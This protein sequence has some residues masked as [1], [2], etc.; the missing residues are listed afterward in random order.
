MPRLSGPRAITLLWLLFA[1]SA[2]ADKLR[3]TSKPA[4]ATVELDGV[5]VG[6]TPLER[7]WIQTDA[8]INPG[9]SGGPLL[10]SRGPSDRDQHE[11]VG[12]TGIQRSQFCAQPERSAE[13]AGAVLSAGFAPSIVVDRNAECGGRDAGCGTE[14]IRHRE[15]RFRSD[16]R[17][18]IS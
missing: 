9:N 16:W 6:T 13:S 8:S 15:H 18:D 14:W 1:T 3:V 5:V 7:D 10:N 17:G 2:R 12:G 4:G 11:Q